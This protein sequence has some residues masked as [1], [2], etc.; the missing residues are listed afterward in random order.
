MNA[1][2]TL[3]MILGA[4]V[5]ST[6]L[7]A[8]QSNESTLS[9]LKSATWEMYHLR[10]S[11]YRVF[12]QY[13]D[14]KIV[15]TIMYDDQKS[16]DERDFYLSDQIETVFDPQKIGRSQHGKYIVIR[17]EPKVADAPKISVV[18]IVDVND[19]ELRV[20]GIY[21]ESESLWNASVIPDL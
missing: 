5:L 3:L 11:T 17:L 20:K 12:E 2:K 19:K 1:M 9:K 16:V 15:S 10:K 6:Q 13:T 7:S 21:G 14:S 4:V 8:G 18:E